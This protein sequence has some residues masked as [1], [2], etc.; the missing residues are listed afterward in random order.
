MSTQTPTAARP[1]RRAVVPDPPGG[2]PAH[3]GARPARAPGEV[4]GVGPVTVQ[5][6]FG[7]WTWRAHPDDRLPPVSTGTDPS[8]VGTQILRAFA[9]SRLLVG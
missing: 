7:G 5:E 3:P 2:S 9:W 4:A 8:G 1:D 6:R